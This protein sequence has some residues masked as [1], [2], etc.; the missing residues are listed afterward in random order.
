MYTIKQ[1]AQL[2]GVP[3]ATLRAW[4][5]RY[6][7]PA[8]ARSAGGYRL[9]DEAAVAR[10]RFMQQLVQAGWAP[11]NAAAVALD[12]AE[13]LV[14]L[15][16]PAEF[17]AAVGAGLAPA[18]RQ[19]LIAARFRAEPLPELIEDWLMPTLR[20]LGEAWAQG[21]VT[22][23]QEHAVASTVLRRLH[24][25]FESTPNPVDGPLVLTGLP[26]GC[27]HEVGLAAFNVLARLA[28]LQVVYLGADL[29]EEAW[30]G[31]VAAHP[32][33]AVVIAV[34]TEEDVPGARAALG[35]LRKREGP[36]ALGPAPLLLAGGGCQD[37]VADLAQGL[38]H[39]L[40]QA[41]ASLR[42]ALAAPEPSGGI[43]AHH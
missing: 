19:A 5:R 40:T 11:R 14:E 36:D 43:D 22:V 1:A 38:G 8:P 26:S 9:Y 34:P 37:A 15:P 28:G 6:E 18:R 4:E 42:T 41:A 23:W 31:A 3:T 20:E 16:T 24:V 33:A 12:G 30:V 7:L 39:S 13:H 35:A 2:S 21:R 10:F 32:P 17:V 25:A 27:H 29:P